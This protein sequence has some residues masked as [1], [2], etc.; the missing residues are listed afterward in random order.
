MTVIVERVT[1]TSPATVDKYAELIARAFRP[2]PFTK[3]L[4]G[5]EGEGDDDPGWLRLLAR[6][7]AE[8][9][10]GVRDLEVWSAR[11]EG[12]DEPG[13]AMI[14]A[15]PGVEWGKTPHADN[16]F[17]RE[18]D[19]RQT[20]D[21][22]ETRKTMWAYKAQVAAAFGPEGE[23][24]RYSVCWLATAPGRQRQGLAAALISHVLDRAH[25]EANYVTLL[26]QT[27]E[28]VKWYLRFGF[29][30]LAAVEFQV[31]DVQG[32]YWT[33]SSEREEDRRR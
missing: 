16:E 32:G 29:K 8:V 5:F 24:P 4:S 11:R 3:L 25:A 20:E 21:L 27:K 10:A 19:A 13:A 31:K 12:D 6:L 28:N 7:K 9:Y 23:T 15:P 17:S 26:T 1:D 33:M 2:I 30:V 14:V 22:R 18:M